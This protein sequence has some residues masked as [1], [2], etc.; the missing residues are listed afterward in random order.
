MKNGSLAVAVVVIL[1]ANALAL[2]HA[3]RNRMG[4]PEAEITLTN[5][6]LVYFRQS[7]SDEDSGITLRLAWVDLGNLAG[8]A[9][10]DTQNWLDQQKLEKLGFD[11]RVNPSSRD[12]RRFYERQRPRQVFVALENDG[13]AWRDWHEAEQRRFGPVNPSPNSVTVYG[14]A[15]SRLMAIDADRDA[16]QLRARHPDRGSV[17]ILPGVV[18]IW[19]FQAPSRVAPQLGSN[20]LPPRLRGRIE[21]LPA[22]VF[23]PR[24]FS[25]AIRRLGQ[26]SR[27]NPNEPLSYRV[28]LRYGALMEP[29]VTGVEFPVSN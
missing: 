9:H 29:W 28:H 18:D 26:P 16:V 20:S 24:P 1:V 4:R 14:D 15:G 3:F 11:C 2:L 7:P 22:D 8:F 17:L 21:Q 19:L 6:E 12:A 10:A 5:R 27:L 13:P 25:D 23:V